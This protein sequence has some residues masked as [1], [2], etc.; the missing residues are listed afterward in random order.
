M[1]CRLASSYRQLEK[2]RCFRLQCPAQ[3]LVV[4]LNPEDEDTMMLRNVRAVYQLT[5]QHR[6]E[7]LKS[8]IKTNHIDGFCICLQFL[9]LQFKKKTL[10]DNCHADPILFFHGV[11]VP[12]GPR[13]PHYRG[14]TIALRH[15]TLGRTPL[16]E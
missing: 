7:N 3:L 14:F 11:A 6:C 1:P 13:P 9:Y 4:L 12:S 2:S 16:D 5:Q 8:R 10:N 15:T